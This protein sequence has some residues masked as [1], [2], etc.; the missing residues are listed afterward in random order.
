LRTDKDSTRDHQR[1]VFFE[2]GNHYNRKLHGLKTPERMV[3]DSYFRT[4][5]TKSKPLSPELLSH[6]KWKY[7]EFLQEKKEG[8]R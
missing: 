4:V 3:K 5:G 6:R 2:V 8:E 7:I 1:K